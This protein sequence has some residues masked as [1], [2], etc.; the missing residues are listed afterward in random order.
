MFFKKKTKPAKEISE[1]KDV[2]HCF[3][4]GAFGGRGEHNILEG[5]WSINENVLTVRLK[6]YY[7]TDWGGVSQLV[8]ETEFEGS[9]SFE[10]TQPSKEVLKD[11]VLEIAQN[12]KLRFFNLTEENLIFLNKSKKE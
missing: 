4:V 9:W 6:D 11:C 5:T 2:P 3:P 7:F 10:G 1:D 12:P 8:S